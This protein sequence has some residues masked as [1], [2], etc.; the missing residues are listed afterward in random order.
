MGSIVDG[1][2]ALLGMIGGLMLVF[3]SLRAS[4]TTYRATKSYQG[5]HAFPSD[6]QQKAA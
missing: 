5:I 4:E 3:M 1:T 2:M 6:S